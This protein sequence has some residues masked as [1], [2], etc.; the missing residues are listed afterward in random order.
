MGISQDFTKSLFT[1]EIHMRCGECKG[2]ARAQIVASMS[3]KTMIDT[4]PVCEGRG[5]IKKRIDD[6]MLKELL[7]T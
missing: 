7:K 1:L 2:N 6:K 4:C 5:Y 3:G